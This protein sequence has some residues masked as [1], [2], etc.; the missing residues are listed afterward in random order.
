MINKGGEVSMNMDSRTE[1]SANDATNMT[2]DELI[3]YAV[4]NDVMLR[5]PTTHELM[6]SKYFHYR[7]VSRKD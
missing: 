1:I 6:S 7:G 5:T 4:K 2:A 3:D